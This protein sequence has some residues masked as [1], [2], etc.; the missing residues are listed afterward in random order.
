MISRLTQQEGGAFSRD[1]WAFRMADDGARSGRSRAG[2]WTMMG[3][4]L[5]SFSQRA[6]TIIGRYFNWTYHPSADSRFIR[7]RFKVASYFRLCRMS[8]RAKSTL[9]L[10]QVYLGLSHRNRAPGKTVSSAKSVSD[11]SVA[12][13]P[14]SDRGQADHSALQTKVERR[15]TFHAHLTSTGRGWQ[16]CLHC[17]SWNRSQIHGRTGPARPWS[18]GRRRD[19]KLLWRRYYAVRQLK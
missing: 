9:G 19:C 14:F 16:G 1:I 13:A 17:V 10:R 11:R 6:V 2:G 12:D 18:W 8:S 5:W 4:L 7:L 15:T 3:Q